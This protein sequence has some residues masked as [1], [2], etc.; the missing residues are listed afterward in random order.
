MLFSQRMKELRL[1]RKLDQQS[2]ADAIG[3]SYSSISM[4]ENNNRKPKDLKTLEKIADF[5]GVTVDYMIGRSNIREASRNTFI[6]E[7][8]KLLRDNRSITEYA[9]FLGIDEDL[10]SRYENGE[11]EPG[12]SF[13]DFI[14][15]LEN[16]DREYFFQRNT[17]ETLKEM[18]IKIPLIQRDQSLSFLNDEV[19]SWV[20]N[21]ESK[22]FLEFFYTKAIK[23]GILTKQQLNKA[24]ITI[25]LD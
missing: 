18:Q 25:R 16:I 21:P 20:E 3:L 23:S 1:E 9:T 17:K 6:N 14:S 12:S 15:E 19:R 4:Y 5:F 13:V 11:E 7:N 8:L 24:Q 22:E 10:Y 2:V